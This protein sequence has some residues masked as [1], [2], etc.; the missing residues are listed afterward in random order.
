MAQDRPKRTAAAESDRSGSPRRSSGFGPRSAEGVHFVPNDGGRFP[1]CGSWRSNWNHTDDVDRA[2]CPQCRARLAAPSDSPMVSGGESKMPDTISVVHLDTGL[3]TAFTND[4]VTSDVPADI[5]EHTTEASLDEAG[6]LHYLGGDGRDHVCQVITRML[7]DR[8][9][10][11]V[12]LL[13]APVTGS[14]RSGWSLLE[15]CVLEPR[16]AGRGLLR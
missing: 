8:A 5:A 10:S 2:T 13:P 16:P 11:D 7:G 4:T 15:V 14:E 6:H 9:P 3:V 12:C 1:L